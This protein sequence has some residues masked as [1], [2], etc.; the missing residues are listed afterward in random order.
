M[1]DARLLGTFF[2]STLDIRFSI[3]TS[4]AS[5]LVVTEFMNSA[6]GCRTCASAF[7]ML[8]DVVAAEAVEAPR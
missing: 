3:L 7:S 6:I 5:Q 1:S 2:S 4:R 8:C